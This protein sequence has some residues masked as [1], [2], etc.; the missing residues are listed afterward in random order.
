MDTN[1]T[2]SSIVDHGGLL[3]SLS[4]E[5]ELFSILNIL[6]LLRAREIMQLGLMFR[7]RAF[8]SS[9]LLYITLLAP[10]GNDH[11]FSIHQSLLENLSQPAHL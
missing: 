3:R 5:N 9:R 4:P 10:L 2:S 6:S 8:V 7:V 11:A 1:M